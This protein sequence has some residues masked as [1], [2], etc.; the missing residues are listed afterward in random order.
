MEKI[1]T[2][3]EL[4]VRWGADGKIRGAHYQFVTR[5]V[6]DGEIVTEKLSD[7]QP[8]GLDGSGDFPLKDILTKAQADALATANAKI[9]EAVAIRQ[10]ASE[11][12]TAVRVE[13]AE[14]IKLA[15]TAQGVAQTALEAALTEVRVLERRAVEAERAAGHLHAELAQMKAPA[16]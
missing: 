6:E 8:I 16:E 12:V 2:P 3:Y 15:E 11:E 5:Y 10:A 4:L 1:T 9:A 14:T 13:C 7:A